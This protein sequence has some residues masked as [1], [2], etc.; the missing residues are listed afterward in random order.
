MKRLLALL[1]CGAVLVSWCAPNSWTQAT[2]GAI[3]GYVSDPS[4]A[5]VPGA[6]VTVTEVKTGIV[7]KGVAD[8]VGLYNITHL[9]PGEYTVV[10]EAPGFKR[11]I[12]AHVTLQVDSTVRI[13][14]RLELGAVS[15]EVSV[16]AAPPLLKSEKTDVARNINEQAIEALPVAAHNLSKLFDIVPGAVE[17]VLQIGEGETPSGATSVTVN[18]M[19]FG[20]NEYV[21]DG[22]T[23]TAC[24]FSNQIV[25][26]PN[27]DSVAELKMAAGDYDPEFGNSAGLI[28]QYVTKSGTN[29]IHGSVWWTNMNKATFA[30][31][32]FTEK[33]PNTGPSGKGTGPAPFNQ[34]QGAFS[35]GGPIRENKM[36]IF[37]DYQ[38]LRRRQGATLTATVPNDAF[39]N[40]DF[41]AV[42]ATNPIYD[43]ATGNPDGTGRQQF[44]CQGALN[45]ICPDRINPVT[46]NLLALLPRANISQ[47]TD[48][49]F[50]GS[51]TVTFRTDQ[52]DTRWDWN[53]S[54]KDKLFVRNTYLYSFLYN[55]PLFGV[56]AGGPPVG[57]LASEAVPTYDDGVALNYTHTFGPSLLAEFRGGLLRWHLLGYQT[58]AGLKTNDQVGIKGLNLGGK[59]TGGLAGFVI[60]GPL[61]NFIEGP[62]PNNVALPRLDIINVWE[63]V[64]NWTL[65]RGKH[66]I[67]W[68]TD[69]RRNMEDLFTINAHTN[70]FFEF[71]QLTTA[72]P[73]VS[74]SGIG[75]AAFLLGEP[76]IFQRGV[77]NFIPHERQWR[78]AFYGQDV[79]RV[80]P[81]L[82]ANYG[83]RWD[84]FGPDETDLKGG[85]SNFDPKTGELLLANLGGVSKTANV[86]GY[87]KGF[88]PRLGLA[89]KLTDNTVVRTGLGRSYFATNYSSTFQQLSIVYPI[90]PTQS[91]LQPNIYQP[92]F[93]LDQGVPPTPPFDAPSSGHLKAPPGVSIFYNPPYTKT[94]HVD[95][96]N[97][98][99]ERLFGRDLRVSLAYIGNKGT[100]L[101]WNPNI[102]AANLAPGDILSHRPY[103]QKYG[104]PQGI[105]SRCTCADSNYNAM[106]FIVDKRF[107]NG[108]SLTSAFTWS[109][110]LDHEIAGFSWGDQSTNPYDRKGS[111]G[112]GNNQDRAAV[113]TLTHQWQLPYGPGLRWGS[114]ATGAN[115]ALLGGWEFNG[116]TIVEDGF[117]LSPILGDGSTLNADWGQRP[118]RLPGVPLYPAHQTT[119]EWF[120]PAA[121]KA[122]QFPDPTV[123]CCR[124]GNAARGSIRG[125]GLIG[126]DWALWKEFRLKTPLNREDTLL[127]FRWENFN[128]LNHPP[129]GEPN[130]VTDSSL[131]GQITGLLGTFLK[132]NA[133]TMR[134]MEF[135]VRLQF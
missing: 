87:D 84:Y 67:R 49:N 100:N 5:A 9:D 92:I 128:A 75:T 55:P 124:W 125:P 42:A 8:S 30:A 60:D 119:A 16:T 21:I 24:C 98:T 83:L 112:I 108:Y 20:A 65:M 34:N 51:G 131:A 46:K 35:L 58:D 68:G 63:G 76:S 45:V 127:Q 29:E 120:N 26:V 71:T 52:F 47:R 32:P 69:I 64:N 111:Y 43:P 28:A 27:Q 25:F 113:W 78:N 89:Y 62:G 85:L 13:D 91:V 116:V 3:S 7:T 22:I 117:A 23:D 1:F 82:T 88:A 44:S 90:A 94:E 97:L 121:F 81:K 53:I 102:N 10:V 31:D 11:F 36:F 56:V 129:L 114:T 135:T 103:Y 99:V 66:Q 54:D 118:D 133:V 77:F 4:G 130:T 96:W 73:A 39:R 104:L 86:Q 6:N 15:Q 18:G 37:G 122:P 38:F 126:T 48:L 110:A 74:A 107:T 2:W 14:P 106:Q 95:Q 33:I 132:A 79:W 50:V 93:P 72:N 17:N 61:G 115:K 105:G 109:K 41:S 57:G 123:H 80:T 101:A 12:Q 134:R 19:W 40:G 70:G 59:I